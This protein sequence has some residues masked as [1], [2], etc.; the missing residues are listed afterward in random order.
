M[1]GERSKGFFPGLP[2]PKLLEREISRAAQL[3]QNGNRAHDEA[4]M[5]L[6]ILG[7]RGVLETETQPTPQTVSGEP[8]GEMGPGTADGPADGSDFGGV[9]GLLTETVRLLTLLTDKPEDR[10]ASARSIIGRKATSSDQ[11]E[12]VADWLVP[13]ERTGK[14]EEISLVSDN[15]AIAQYRL[16][17]ASVVQWA[18]LLLPTSLAISFGNNEIAGD[19][20]VLV[21]V[22]SDGA[23]PIVAHGAISATERE[24]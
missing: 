15:P 20:Q 22:K 14:L 21:E 13:P 4:D 17:I 24:A 19:Q 10:P 7:R 1:N 23:T 9:E 16:T 12:A 11:Y 8:E 6:T 2:S 5:E 3:R 18:D